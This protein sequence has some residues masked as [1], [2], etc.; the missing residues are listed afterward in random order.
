MVG[1][2]GWAEGILREEESR[3]VRLTPEE[4]CHSLMI[5][6]DGGT[7]MPKSLACSMKLERL[8]DL[9]GTLTVT[10]ST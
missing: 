8:F 3:C 5:R 6:F 2:L 7:D 1:P 9:W 10:G 4:S